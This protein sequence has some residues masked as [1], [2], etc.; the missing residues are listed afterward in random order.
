MLILYPTQVLTE[1][2]AKHIEE[3]QLFTTAYNQDTCDFPDQGMWTWFD[4]VILKSAKSDK[5]KLGDDGRELVWKS[6]DIDFYLPKEDDELVEVAG[7]VID[8]SHDLIQSLRVSF[9][10]RNVAP[11]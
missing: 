6:H 5:P 1:S 11:C 8:R 2:V 9:L 10:W 3:I 7:P 4:F